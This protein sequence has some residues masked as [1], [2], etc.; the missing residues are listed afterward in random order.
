MD[1]IYEGSCPCATFDVE[2]VRIEV[3]CWRVCRACRYSGVHFT[4]GDDPAAAVRVAQRVCDA[5][6]GMGWSQFEIQHGMRRL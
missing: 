2:G 1:P 6:N 3:H 4:G 5:L